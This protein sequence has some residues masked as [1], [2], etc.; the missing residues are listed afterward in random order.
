MA[1]CVSPS[2]NW[3]CDTPSPWGL[4]AWQW[5]FNEM[6]LCCLHWLQE[7]HPPWNLIFSVYSPPCPH[8]LLPSFLLGKEP[9]LTEPASSHPKKVLCLPECPHLAK[10]GVCFIAKGG[11][12]ISFFP[13]QS[14]I[15]WYS[16]CVLFMGGPMGS[17]KIRVTQVP[18]GT[19]DP[20]ER[21]KDKGVPKKWRQNTG[22]GDFSH[23]G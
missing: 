11:G 21:N 18:L 22:E 16:Y 8:P 7:H 20:G 1:V 15:L 23:L 19:D 10:E 12:Q 17:I 9:S 6:S 13:T 5:L 4:R 3:G 14:S 2:C